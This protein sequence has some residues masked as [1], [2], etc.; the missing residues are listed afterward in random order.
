MA[1]G[2]AF[3]VTTLATLTKPWP[4]SDYWVH[5]AVIRTLAEGGELEDIPLAESPGYFQRHH[6]PHHVL[7]ALVMRHTGL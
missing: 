5:L 6:D 1:H 2:A 3:V 4:A 7:W